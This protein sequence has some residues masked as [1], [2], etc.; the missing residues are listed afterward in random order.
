MA[1]LTF[2]TASVLERQITA[3]RGVVRLDQYATAE[4]L[5]SGSLSVTI[6]SANPPS[7]PLVL[8]LTRAAG[9]W[10]LSPEALSNHTGTPVVLPEPMLARVNRV[11]ADDGIGLQRDWRTKTHVLRTGPR[12]VLPMVWTGRY[13]ATHTGAGWVGTTSGTAPTPV[14]PTSPSPNPAPAPAGSPS[15]AMSGA[16]AP[17]HHPT[18]S[19]SP[20]PEPEPEPEP[21]PFVPEPEE[22]VEV[23]AA[24]SAD[25]APATGIPAAYSGKVV[26]SKQARAK[27]L[28][29]RASHKAGKPKVVAFVGPSGAGKTH[30]VHALS[31]AE[32][33]SVVKFDASGVIEPGDWFGTVVLDGDGTRFVP[34]DLLT[35]LT[36]PGERTLLVDEVNRA[37]LR[38][39]NAML[40][41]FEYAGAVTIPQT[42]KRERLNRNVQIVVTANM[43]SAF[44]GVEPLDEAIRTRVGL[45]V[46]VDHLAE[47]EERKLLLARVPGLPEQQATN[48][49]RLGAAIRMAAQNG[50]HPPVSTRQLLAAADLMVAGLDPR[51]AVDAAVLDGYSA[52]G[53]ESSE[54]AKVLVHVTGIIWP[55]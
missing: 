51:L 4:R 38:A 13:A 53:G 9:Q 5:P 25:G 43:G 47:S 30:A 49:A 46:E 14:P 22:G 52:E 19:P 42:G 23:G 35:A 7:D 1:R 50:Q 34:S 18:A 20:Q 32:G 31:A 16:V 36:Q 26:L 55:D 11:L 17:G 44:L 29:A 15:A 24:L 37:N 41:V 10:I 45:W 2:P 12:R 27:W 6:R 39:L 54:R 21:E 40:P 8:R 33:L 3:S 28:A 48:L